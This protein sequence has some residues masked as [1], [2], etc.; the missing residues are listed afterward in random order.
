MKAAPSTG[1]S[2]TPLA[3]KLSLKGDLRTWREGMPATVRAEIEAEGVA[4]EL[5]PAPVAPIDAAHL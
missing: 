4:L 1:Y 3:C 5:L 2:A